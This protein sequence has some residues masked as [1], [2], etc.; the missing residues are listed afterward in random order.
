MNT[1]ILIFILILFGCL[2]Y[3]AWLWA[4]ERVKSYNAVTRR[5]NNRRN[6]RQ[7]EINREFEHRLKYLEISERREPMTKNL[8]ATANPFTNMEDRY[9]RELKQVVSVND[10]PA[11]KV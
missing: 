2:L 9:V 10:L 5:A 4:F 8:A 7:L 6:K 11:A 1:P 3:F